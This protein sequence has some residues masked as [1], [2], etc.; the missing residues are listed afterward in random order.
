MAVPHIVCIVPKGLL[1]D[2]DVHDVFGAGRELRN[3]AGAKSRPL[4]IV[5]KREL[6][7]KRHFSKG[8]PQILYLEGA[9]YVP[10]YSVNY[11]CTGVPTCDGC[12]NRGV[13]FGHN[14]R[15]H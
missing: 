14:L 6:N 5:C 2:V 9:G 4:G 3:L 13:W 1:G 15:E 7:Q 10:R 8:C 12:F 11:T